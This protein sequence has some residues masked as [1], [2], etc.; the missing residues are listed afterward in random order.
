[1]Q[2]NRSREPYPS[3]G[4]HKHVQHP[5][6]RRAMHQKKKKNKKRN[7]TTATPFSNDSRRAPRSRISADDPISH[8]GPSL[9]VT[10]N[11][12][13]AHNFSPLP[14][15]SPMFTLTSQARR[16]GS[17]RS[18]SIVYTTEYVYYTYIY[19]YTYIYTRICTR[20]TN[21]NERTKRDRNEIGIRRTSRRES[22]SRGASTTSPV[23]SKT[24]CSRR[25][26]VSSLC[27]GE[28]I[29]SEAIR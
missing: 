19:V 28:T 21:E 5:V 15:S 29:I 16:P 6:V 2:K 4:V 25:E 20:D 7:E 13:I 26:S 14:W 12:I 24:D 1:M 27:T 11:A 9:S 18:G 8:E 22:R 3:I 17:S 23:P 10:S